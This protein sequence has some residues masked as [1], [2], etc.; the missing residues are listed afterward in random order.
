MAAILERA[1][2]LDSKGRISIPKEIRDQAGLTSGAQLGISSVAGLIILYREDKGLDSFDVFARFGQLLREK[3]YDTSEKI[4][5]LVKEIKR[6]TTEDWL[7]RC[8]SG[9]WP[10]GLAEK[11]GLDCC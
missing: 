3:G 8:R 7:R 10:T 4:D 9:A 11:T 1:I 6:E 5:R 2:V